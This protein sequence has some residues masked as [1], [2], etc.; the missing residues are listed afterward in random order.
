MEA[1]AHRPEVSLDRV[2]LHLRTA[3]GALAGRRIST[4]MATR[5]LL[6]MSIPMQNR[7]TV[8]AG[9]NRTHI[10]PTDICRRIRRPIQ[11][12]SSLTTAPTVQS[13]RRFVHHAFWP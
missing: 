2:A 6:C 13:A 9:R 11:S 5:V 12:P 4:R 1:G 3:T 8:R 7:M 10:I